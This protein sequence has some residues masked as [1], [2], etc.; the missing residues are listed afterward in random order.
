LHKVPAVGFGKKGAVKKLGSLISPF[1]REFGLEEA[2]RFD[3]IKREWSNTFGEPLSAHM[4]PARLKNGE[5]LVNVDSPLW[6]QQ[7]TF[8]KTQVVGKLSPFGVKELRFIL[9]RVAPAR[10]QEVR[11]TRTKED[12]LGSEATQQIEDTIAGTD[13]MALKE[14]IRKAMKKAL[15]DRRTK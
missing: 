10:R 1:V 11:S 8:L 9:G 6:L 7:L 3:L 14:S 13:D 5:L 15:A 4:S 2:V 12:T